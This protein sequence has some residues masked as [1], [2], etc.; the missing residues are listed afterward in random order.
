MSE[1]DVFATRAPPSYPQR[2]RSMVQSDCDKEDIITPPPPSL[3]VTKSDV[4]PKPPRRSWTA[5]NLTA[6]LDDE[7]MDN[8]DP[9]QYPSSYITQ[10]SC[11]RRKSYPEIMVRPILP[12]HCP[13]GASTAAAMAA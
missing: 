10:T 4:I 1:Q 7:P 2:R 6:L 13:L 11:M 3:R 5:Q 8:S 9:S 12:R